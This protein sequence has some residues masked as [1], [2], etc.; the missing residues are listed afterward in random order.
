M[1]MIR[2]TFPFQ[3][4]TIDAEAG[5][6]EAI[7]STEEVDR[8]GD[9][10]RAA[11]A[12]LTQYLL[13][14][15]VLAGHD[16]RNL[17]SVVGKAL[18]VTVVSGQGIKARFQFAPADVNPKAEL[19]RR[20]WASEFVNATSIGFI[21]KEAKPRE[22]GN[23]YEF[24]SWELLEFS[25]VSVPSN[26]S[27]L[28]LRTLGELNIAETRAVN[29]RALD[30]LR[31]YFE[32]DVSAALEKRGRVLSAAN[33]QKLKGA[34]DALN[35]VLA[36]LEQ[37]ANDGK[38]ASNES[39]EISA[40]PEM[41]ELEAT[42]ENETS[43]GENATNDETGLP[44]LSVERELANLLDSSVLSDWLKNIKESIP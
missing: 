2:K 9:I 18:E 41:A 31:E 14:P 40:I 15:V 5:I 24:T 13:N 44:A 23:G 21:P 29:E 1:T 37:E 39:A 30:L 26:Q 4:K 27:A 42:D 17:D 12:D 16:Y 33:E 43:V 10:V 28:A 20:L 7:I 32:L 25:V 3:R 35:E 36:Q 34:R 6:Y 8:D 22:N 11:G 19:V 38:A